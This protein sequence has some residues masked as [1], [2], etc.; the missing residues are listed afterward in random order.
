VS[1]EGAASL[2]HTVRERE[3][4]TWGE[5]LFDV[6]AT[7]IFSLLDLNNPE[8]LKTSA[9]CRSVIWCANKCRTNVDGAEAGTMPCSHVLVE[10]L[11]SI[12][13]RELTEFLVHV[14]CT[15]TGVITEPD[16]KD[17]DFHRPLLVNLCRKRP[18]TKRSASVCIVSPVRLPLERLHGKHTTLTP[19][20]SP[21]A[22]FTFFNCLWAHQ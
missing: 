5:Q 14:M 7:D 22:F 20:I 10:A 4:E 15:G 16:A 9:R 3:A 21:L 18:N 8:D 2:L 1:D 19:M 17:L 13:T 6:W 11:D 12:G